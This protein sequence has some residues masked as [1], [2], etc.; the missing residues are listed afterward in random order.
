MSQTE[1]H[2]IAD[3]RA[4]LEINGYKVHFDAKDWE[5]R[6]VNLHGF[7]VDSDLNLNK[8][9]ERLNQIHK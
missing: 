6:A 9:C 4:K 3:T 8:L 7:G 2:Y 5:W 1:Q